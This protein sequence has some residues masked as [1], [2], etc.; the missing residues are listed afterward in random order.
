MAINEAQVTQ[1]KQQQAQ[2]YV[3]TIYLYVYF[4]GLT[5]ILNFSYKV[6]KIVRNMQN[7]IETCGNLCTELVSK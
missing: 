4:Y 2:V 5:T 6:L 1:K 3:S 7:S